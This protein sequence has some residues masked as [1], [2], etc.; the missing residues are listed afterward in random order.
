ML[1]RIGVLHIVEKKIHIGQGLFVH[2][3]IAKTAGFQRYRYLFFTEQPEQ[4]KEEFR[5]LGWFPAG[6]SNTP[7]T[8]IVIPLFPQHI[9]Q[10]LPCAYILAH[11]IQG[12]GNANLNAGLLPGA[13]FPVYFMLPIHYLMNRWAY[14]HTGAAVNTFSGG[15][16][17]MFLFRNSLRIMTP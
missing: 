1:L 2:L 13:G 17:E 12:F 5:L 9:R 16:G 7:L 3:V 15:K 8:F 6:N 4:G 14:L 11:Y 10:D